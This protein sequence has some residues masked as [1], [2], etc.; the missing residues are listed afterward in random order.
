MNELSLILPEILLT[1]F[2]CLVLVVDVFRNPTSTAVTFWTAVISVLT[3]SVFLIVGGFPET[4]QTAFSETFVLD[5]LSVTLKTFLLLVV[6]GT[7]F[8]AREYFSNQ[9][10]ERNEFFILAIFS[11]LGMMVLIS[12]QSLLTLYLGLE[13]LSLSL[14]AMVAMERDSAAASEAA[15]K[16]FVLGALASGMLLYGMSMLYGVSGTLS[17]SELASQTI[18]GE[19][20]LLFTFG[21]VFV[22]VG[23]AFKLGV[24]PFHMW[25]PDVYQGASLPTTLFISS[26]PK[27]AAFAMA[28]RVLVDGLPGLMAQWSDMLTI[29][30]VASIAIGNVV[31]IAQTNIKRMLAYSTVSHMGFLLLGL[32]AVSNQG[33]A[34]S[35]FYVFV[36][37]LASMSAFGF[38]ILVTASGPD[39]NLISDFSGLGKKKPL[40]GF[41]GMVV[42]FSLAG[43]PPFG[44]FWAKWFVLKELVASGQVWLATVA[45]IFSLV[46]AYYY[47]RV[48]K[49]MFFDEPRGDQHLQ[50]SGGMG[51][52]VFGLN[53]SAI[54]FIGIFPGALMGICL[55]AMSIYGAR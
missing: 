35:M 33:Y 46:G 55:G 1:V 53:T 37:S 22:L 39:L 24:V 52:I 54:M 26:A 25:V 3:V 11:T 23:V 29:L 28:V 31:A 45:V 42:L 19:K 32:I 51:K 48:I 6:V 41:L 27:I 16:Y 44:G 50:S 20:N 9:N 49:V 8:Y 30:A 18:G 10:L 4:R 34:A 17:L 43:V 12:A 47:L 21:L 7:F 40:L 14:Y 5:P 36:Y 13:L 38:I 2:A 15:M